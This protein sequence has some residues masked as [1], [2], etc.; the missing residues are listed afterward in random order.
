LRDLDRRYRLWLVVLALLVTLPAFAG[1]A[2]L[3]WER[4]QAAGLLSLIGCALLCGAPVRPR[5]AQP[6]TL[7]SL[8]SHTLIG[9]AALVAVLLHIAALVLADH[10]V[11]EYLKPTMPLYAWAG[12][13]GT[14]LLGLLVVSALSS[15]RRRL[16]RSNASFQLMHVMASCALL[17][18]IGAHVITTHRYV[19]G[20]GRSAWMIAAMV[21]AMLML[22]RPR[23]GAPR[24]PSTLSASGASGA[25]GALGALG[26]AGTAGEAGEARAP[27]V[28]WRRSLAFGR[29]AVAIAVTIG[30]VA[31][32]LMGMPGD[33]ARATLREP[34]IARAVT[35]PLAFPH[36]KH[37]QVNC[38]ECHHNYADGTG[39]DWCIHCHR[40]ARADLK[41]GVEARFHGFCL[42]CHRD[43]RAQLHAHGPVAGCSACHHSADHGGLPR[44]SDAGLMRP[45]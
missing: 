12:L 40:S 16:F 17:A 42:Q 32:M 15:V 9:W 11:L 26:T 29:H 31:I 6:P 27:G 23:R 20:L 22:L 13:L 21:G 36:E 3:A 30:L 14:L 44:E 24:A 1:F 45:P 25:S 39:L 2:G 10:T 35:L 7:L 43:P 33:A 18:L 37:G 4:A 19:G 8:P 5:A 34:L 28:P 41:E 38:L